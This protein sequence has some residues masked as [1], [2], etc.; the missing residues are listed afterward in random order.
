MEF[1]KNPHVQNFCFGSLGALFLQGIKI[2]TAIENELKK[3]KDNLPSREEKYIIHP[4]YYLFS[5]LFII[6]GGVVAAG[7]MQE[8]NAGCWAKSL[9]IGAG[10]ETI[11]TKPLKFLGNN[12]NADTNNEDN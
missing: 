1:L 8:I 9:F 3:K 11:I 4:I 6:M 7:L 2:S 5:I 12:K 10:S